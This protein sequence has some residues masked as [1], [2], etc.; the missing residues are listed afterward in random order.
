MATG[1]TVI[2][3][4][5]YGTLL[6]T[7]S[8]AHELAKLYGD[9]RTFSEITR[10]SLTHALSEH[11]FELSAGKT[12]QLM[13]AYDFLHVFP[14]IPAALKLVRE[15]SNLVDA[16]I[17][18][19]G[20]LE[21]VGTS[22]KSSPDLGPHAS[23]FKSLITVD[24]VKC[25]K[26]AARVYEHLVKEAG[27]EGSKSDVWLVSGNPFDVVGAKSAG[28]KAAWIDRAGKG[29]VD[30]LDTLH[31]PSIIATGVEDAVKSILGWVKDA[32]ARTKS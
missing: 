7:E 20:T 13:Q 30:R 14:E 15:N 18:S 11:G 1:K 31:V 32:K 28:L 2:A 27:K 9:Y 29:W 21:M 22:V 3:F 24:D 25:Y 8:I 26:P 5:L 4:D 12:D 23:L 19:N 6:S 10:G 17:F 16:Y